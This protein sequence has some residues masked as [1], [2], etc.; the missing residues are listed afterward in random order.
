MPIGSNRTFPVVPQL[1]RPRSKLQENMSPIL[2]VQEVDSNHF[3]T[4]IEWIRTMPNLEDSWGS[5][6]LVAYHQGWRPEE[7]CGNSIDKCVRITLNP[8]FVDWSNVQG[9]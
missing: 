4:T 5:I 8:Y 7:S 3:E 2:S 1:S 6:S 9:N